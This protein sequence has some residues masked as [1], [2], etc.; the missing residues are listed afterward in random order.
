MP[1]DNIVQPTVI[2]PGQ[3]MASPPEPAAP[4]GKRI[5]ITDGDAPAPTAA[6]VPAQP[7]PEPPKPSEA[8]IAPV[9]AAPISPE[10]T[11][12]QPARPSNVQMTGAI[13]SPPR[14]GDVPKFGELQPK[15]DAHPLFSG[16]KEPAPK[17]PRRGMRKLAWLIG[18][19]LAVIIALYLLV[20]AGVVKGASHLPFHVFKQPV[21][22][23]APVITPSATSSTTA[24]PYAGWKTYSSKYVTFNFKYPNDWAIK[25][26]PNTDSASQ[27]AIE[28]DSPVANGYY[29]ALEFSR[30]KATEVYQNFLGS[31]PC[32]SIS[33]SSLSGK[34]GNQSLL[35][36][37]P[38]LRNQ[39]TGLTVA[40]TN[41]S[42]GCSLGLL[43]PSGLNG[44]NNITLS[45]NLIAQ[46][47]S[48]AVN[49]TLSLDTYQTNLQYQNIL[50][51]FE[52]I[53]R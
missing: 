46:G 21:A 18:F 8:P 42:S 33:G 9:M 30:G 13:T 43:D 41:D 16:A 48:S 45:A 44:V 5:T 7:A 6:A 22:A 36:V 51:V 11:T 31:A 38:G 49:Q 2:N 10:P 32:E 34:Y 26:G 35:L 29:F 53:N 40:T 50:K 20:D 12:S 4:I 39:V 37:A 19:L 14:P 47:A 15:I 23:T 17:R 28:I 3:P 24:D 1:E 25:A 52:S 27:E